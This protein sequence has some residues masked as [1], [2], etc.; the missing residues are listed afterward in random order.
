M[1]W[2]NYLVKYFMYIATPPLLFTTLG[3]DIY[4]SHSH[5]KFLCRLILDGFFYVS[6]IAMIS[7]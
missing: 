2:L 4:Y 6:L 5:F 1:H 7:G 3:L